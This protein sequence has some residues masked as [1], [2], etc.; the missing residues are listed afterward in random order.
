MSLSI[1][2]QE[3]AKKFIPGLTQ[4]LSKNPTRFSEE[5]GHRTFQK[6]KAQLCGIWMGKNTSICR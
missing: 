2:T 5:S 1:S 4:L 3:R 6:Q